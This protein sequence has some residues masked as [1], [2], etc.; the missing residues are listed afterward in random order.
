MRSELIDHMTHLARQA[1][2]Q[3]VELEEYGDEASQHDGYM[4][5]V[6]AVLSTLRAGKGKRAIASL[7]E[8]ECMRYEAERV[9]GITYLRLWHEG[10]VEA[11]Q[12]AVDWIKARE[13]VA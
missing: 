2:R 11:V 8:S 6:A 3:A 1:D 13:E 10:Y 9:G 12:G 4:A 7:V 5:G